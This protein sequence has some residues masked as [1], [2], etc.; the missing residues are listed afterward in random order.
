LSST[1]IQH[2]VI[3]AAGKGTRMGGVT[4]ETPKPMLL[5]Q[6]KPML[7]HIL[8]GLTAAGVE[9]L[10]VVV[11]YRHQL[12]EQYFRGWQSSQAPVPHALK[13]EFRVQDPVD[14]TGT[15]AQLAKEFAG[16]ESFLL[17]YAD[18]LCGASEYVRCGA[19][20]RQQPTTAAVLAVKAVDDPWQGAAVYEEQ[21]RIRSII[22]KPAK[23]TST[24]HWNSAGFYAF[25]PILFQYL[26]RLER[27]A[28]GEYELTSALDRMLDD[29][30]ELRI[31]PVEGKWR[32]VG[33]PEDLLAANAAPAASTSK[34][35]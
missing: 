23:G 21:G 30:L 24:T 15:A 17:T 22:E 19:V 11:G 3:L 34:A 8:E 5:V 31:S 28:R 29:S 9:N 25:R 2:A 13:L 18:I 7:E 26:N 27:S 10:F 16:N 12:I 1:S 33:R 6:G 35:D 20:L 32:D 14:G 4:D